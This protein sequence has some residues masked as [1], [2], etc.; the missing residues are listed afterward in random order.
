MDAKYEGARNK[1]LKRCLFWGFVCLFFVWV[2]LFVLGGGCRVGFG[3]VLGFLILL[4]VYL[5]WQSEAAFPTIQQDSAIVLS[6][7]LHA[8]E[9][10]RAPIL[11]L[12]VLVS[13]APLLLK[14]QL[15]LKRK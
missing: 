2:C 5:S 11:Q 1:V 8:Q 7:R 4:L 14:A 12:V 13:L 6:G 9:G 15:D 3:L 10:G